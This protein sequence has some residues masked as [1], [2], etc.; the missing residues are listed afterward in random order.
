[1]QI[2]K[3]FSNYKHF[4]SDYLNNVIPYLIDKYIIG[5]YAIPMVIL[6][7]MWFSTNLFSIS[8]TV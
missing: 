2:Y 8:Y 5:F 4:E 1:M 7:V 6:L 3:L